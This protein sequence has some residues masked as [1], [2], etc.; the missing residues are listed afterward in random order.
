MTN[1]VNSIVRKVETSPAHFT[2]FADEILRPSFVGKILKH[3]KGEY[4]VGKDGGVLP[5]GTRVV[6]MMPTLATG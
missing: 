5:I 1:S 2:D 4:L 3:L 6:A